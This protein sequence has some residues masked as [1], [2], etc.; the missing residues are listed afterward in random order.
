MDKKPSSELHLVKY[1]MLIPFVAALAL[2]FN[3]TKAAFTPPVI[4]KFTE[5]TIVPNDTLPEK[6]PDWETNRELYKDNFTGYA[7][8]M[9]SISHIGAEDPVVLNGKLTNGRNALN[10]VRQEGIGFAAKLENELAQYY[11]PG[12]N[13]LYWLETKSAGRA[14]NRPDFPPPPEVIPKNNEPEVKEVRFTPPTIVPNKEKEDKSIPPP[15]VKEVKFTP[16]KDTLPRVIVRNIVSPF[17]EPDS[18][19][20]KDPLILLD[21]VQIQQ[22]SGISPDNIAGISM[23]KGE[24]ATS[25]FGK[26]AEGGAML[27]TTKA[28]L[29]STGV[30]VN[31]ITADRSVEIENGLPVNDDLLYIINDV[32]MSAEEVKIVAPGKIES[33]SILKDQ[34]ATDKYGPKGKNGVIEITTKEK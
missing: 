16:A 19:T 7:K 2:A 5:P 3:V 1:L 28:N 12:E 8:T 17:V 30:P 11:I 14:P 21:G 31:E 22:L 13:L 6:A 9:A 20:Q 34:L 29:A 15:T 18:A 24:Q 23:L 27:I 32:Q 10:A 4:V 26:K 33:I 25:L